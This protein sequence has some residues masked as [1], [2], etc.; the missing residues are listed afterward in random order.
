MASGFVF[1]MTRSDP[2]IIGLKPSWFGWQDALVALLV[3]A[4]EDIERVDRVSLGW[5]STTSMAM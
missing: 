4:Q 1:S 3:G 2:V 5:S